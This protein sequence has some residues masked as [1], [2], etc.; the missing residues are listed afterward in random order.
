MYA[1][2]IIT[3]SSVSLVK[4]WI[5]QYSKIL[6]GTYTQSKADW[7]ICLILYPSITFSFSLENLGVSFVGLKGLF[8]WFFLFVERG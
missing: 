6:A 5:K 8:D 3:M 7:M 4:T 1:C 2:Q